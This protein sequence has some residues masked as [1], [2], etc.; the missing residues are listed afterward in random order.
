M[1]GRR[2]IGLRRIS[3][4][5]TALTCA[6]A[7]GCAHR[8][9]TEKTWTFEGQPQHEAPAGW[10]IAA[11]NPT[12]ALAT[13]QVIADPTAPTPPDVFALTGTDNYDGTFNLAIA[14]APEFR[15]L[16]L[17]VDVKPISGKEDQGGG[18]IWRCQDANNYYVC[19]INPLEGNFRLYVVS[20]GKRRQLASVNVDLGTD[21]WY[22]IR[23]RMATDEITC[24]LDG[25]Q[26]LTARDSTIP[27]AGRVGVW[28]KADA[29]TSFDDLHVRPIQPHEPVSIR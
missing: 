24:I 26:V 28:T 2:T 17:N 8:V 18:P 29:V 9:A 19:R 14:D 25:R 4:Y 7:F 12:A 10:K 20:N 15:N 22:P 5:V 16:E 6:G 21:R 1:T 3:L 13:W 11:T 23:V 27:D